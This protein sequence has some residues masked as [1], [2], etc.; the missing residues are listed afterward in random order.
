[1]ARLRLGVVGVGHLGKEHARILAGLPDVTLVGIADPNAAQAEAVAQR[2]GTQAYGDHRNLLEAV[3]AAV[4]AAPTVHHHAVARD[5]LSR[6]LPVLV[7]KPLAATLEH[8]DEMVALARQHKTFLQ[9]GHIERFNPAFEELCR[10]PLRPKYLSSERCGGFS[11]R[12]TDTGVVLDLMI[13][14]IDLVLSLVQAPIA[15]VWA[16]GV[17]VLNGH[18]DIARARITFTN[19]CVADLTASRVHPTPTRRMQVWGAEG[20]A[21]IDFAKRQM[22]LMQR[23]EALRQGHINSRRLDAA[24]AASLKTELF[25]RHIETQ[26]IDC[27]GGDQLTAELRHFASCVRSGATPRVDGVAG[28]NAV[29]LATQVVEQVRANAWEGIAADTLFSPPRRE[30]AA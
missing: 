12:S 30:A 13:H 28:R 3:D 17:S 6:G 16:M 29:E 20:Y 22:T 15:S 25:T 27:A 4:I 24:T 18:E 2:C 14:D 9:V 26:E 21:G 8:A 23:S 5:F 7:E 19:G 11:G 1:M 10:R